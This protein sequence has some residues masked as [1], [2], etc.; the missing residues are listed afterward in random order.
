M[1]P[2]GIDGKLGVSLFGNDVL[3]FKML[4]QLH[5]TDYQAFGS[6]VALELLK[7]R[8]SVGCENR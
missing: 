6:S 8:I 7:K 1:F 3:V 4:E 5:A 2:T